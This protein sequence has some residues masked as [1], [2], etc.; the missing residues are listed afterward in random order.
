MVFKN[1][2]D[3]C[4]NRVNRNH[5]KVIQKYLSNR[6]GM[7]D[8]KELQKEAILGNVHML[9]KVGLLCESTKRSLWEIALRVP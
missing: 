7:H 6:R 5:L 2:S 4:D 9:R 8:I 1:K 3:K